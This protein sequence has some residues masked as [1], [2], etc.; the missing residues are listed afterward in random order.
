MDTSAQKRT[1][2]V[3]GIYGFRTS[4]FTKF[5]PP[6]TNRFAAL[7]V[8]EI[9]DRGVVYVVLDGI[10]DGVPTFE[11]VAQALPLACHRFMFKG[12]IA[13]CSTPVDWSNDLRDFH[14][15][16]TVPVTA[17]ELA[18]AATN[19]RYSSWPA[20]SADAEGE[21]RWR[22]DRQAVEAEVQRVK[23]EQDAKLAADRRAYERRLKGLTWDALLAEIP[24]E[25]WNRHPP[26]PPP[27]FVGAA[28]SR[29]RE[30]VLDLCATGARPTKMAV[31]A[32]LRECVGWFNEQDQAFGGVIE[33]E[34]REDICRVLLELVVVAGH[35]A[36]AEEI[37]DWRD[38]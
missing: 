1:Y 21:W 36:L 20:A 25:R 13:L 5:S 19:R 14:H 6:E 28:R 32:V 7:K 30:A 27:E 11:Q 10:F 29:I 16:A 15:V 4:P 8:L 34:E 31:R 26:F 35:R 17:A 33:T 9:N 37:D 23:A 12:G 3:G 24:F 2:E 38:W 22:H 18:L